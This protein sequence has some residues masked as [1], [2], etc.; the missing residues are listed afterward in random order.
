MFTKKQLAYLY[1][2]AVSEYGYDDT[3]SYLYSKAVTSFRHPL[4][5]DTK[6]AVFRYFDRR[7]RAERRLR[8]KL[9]DY[10]CY[11]KRLPWHKPLG[12]AVS[13]VL[14]DR[15]TGDRIDAQFALVVR[16]ITALPLSL[17]SRLGA[18]PALSAW[19]SNDHKFHTG[20][21]QRPVWAQEVWYVEHPLTAMHQ[22]HISVKDPALVAHTQSLFP[23]LRFER[24]SAWM[25]FR[26][27]LPDSLPVIDRLPRHPGVVVACGHG[28]F[29]MTAAS[30]TARLVSQLVRGEPPAI[31]LSPYRLSR[32]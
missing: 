12:Q 23:G 2:W 11:R 10:T 20:E 28:H 26:P 5:E 27:S 22:C 14:N 17:T 32:F 6:D 13:D 1:A 21:W 19:Y 16:Y 24:S 3:V 9:S 18:H 4:P 31:D 30:M 7:D 25:G 8:A 29:G 15:V